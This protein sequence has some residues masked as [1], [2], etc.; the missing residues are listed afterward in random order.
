VRNIAWAIVI[1]IFVSFLVGPMAEILNVTREKIA[2]NSA[3]SN[4][5]R[6]AKDRSLTLEK[7]REL[8]A[9]IEPSLFTQYFSEAFATAMNFTVESISI[10]YE[11]V[12]F[13]PNDDQYNDFTVTLK[14]DT[15]PATSIEDTP[16]NKITTD[17][18]V[19][20]VTVKAEADY[21]FKTKYLQ[22][23]NDSGKDVGFQLTG[24]STHIIS[25]KN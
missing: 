6:A 21:K 4:A 9:T 10:D 25:V 17:Y 22:I 14:F 24:E 5:I 23:A 12:E 16:T 18:I 13:K 1:V 11:T 20:V 2:L 8:D 15:K 3:L 7:Q 19:T